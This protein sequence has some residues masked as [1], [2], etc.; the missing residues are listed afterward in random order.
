ML[1]LPNQF[2]LFSFQKRPLFSYK[3]ALLQLQTKS[4]N[5]IINCIKNK[6]YPQKYVASR[7]DQYFSHPRP[8]LFVHGKF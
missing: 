6:K 1:D 7:S 2:L 4:H 8:F 5:N 3:Y